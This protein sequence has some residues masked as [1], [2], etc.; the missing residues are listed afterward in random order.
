ME[1]V[2]SR[3]NSLIQSLLIDAIGMATYLVPGLGESFDL[4]VAP[5]LAIWIWRLHGSWIAGSIGFFEEILPYTDIFP[6]ATATWCY[7][8]LLRDRKSESP[9]LAP[10]ALGSEDAGGN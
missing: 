10:P 4:M 6:T 2:Q 8:F 7:R 1:T 9:A 5:I 3:T